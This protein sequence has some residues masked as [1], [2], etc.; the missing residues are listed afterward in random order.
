MA[1]EKLRGYRRGI[2]YRNGDI[3]QE[4]VLKEFKFKG[5][6][7][8]EGYSEKDRKRYLNYTYDALKD[9]SVILNIP[10]NVVSLLNKNQEKPM[11]F[12]GEANKG[13]TNFVVN[14]DGTIV[15]NWV[16]FLDKFLANK[17]KELGLFN[18]LDTLETDSHPARRFVNTLKFKEKMVDKSALTSEILEGY[19][20]SI[21]NLIDSMPFMQGAD[22]DT[23]ATVEDSRS[24]FIKELSDESLNNMISV[25]ENNGLS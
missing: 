7:Y 13:I 1:N 16:Y 4:E 2:P 14:K 5:I 22:M 24:K 19:R 11:L 17:D 8:G 21:Y 18:A 20:D 23:V 10:S 25:F 15:R 12:F 9:L 6:E 3:K